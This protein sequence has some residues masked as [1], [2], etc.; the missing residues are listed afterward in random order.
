MS[1]EESEL[2]SQSNEE[3]KPVKV[4]L[5]EDDPDDQEIFQEALKQSDV[6]AELTIV[7]NGK[8]LVDTLKDNNQENPDIIFLDL[9]MPVK[10]GKEALKEIKTDEELKEIPAVVLSTSDNPKEIKESFQAGANLYLT[11]PNSFKAFVL[12]L[13]KVFSFHWTRSLLRPVWSRFFFSEK[14]ITRGK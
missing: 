1:H 6:N 11:K 5:A 12:L 8:E 4:I 10:D 13:R 7:S 14:N 9:N 3:T 2:A